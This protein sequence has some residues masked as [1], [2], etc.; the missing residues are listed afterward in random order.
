MPTI[1]ICG[2][3]G[4]GKSSLVRGLQDILSERRIAY[5]VIDK[6]AILDAEVQPIC[7]FIAT[8]LE[9]MRVRISQMPPPARVLFLMWSVAITSTP[10]R[11]D[12]DNMVL[13]DGYWMKHAAAEIAMGGSHASIRGLVEMF[14]APDLTIFLDI[15]PTDALARKRGHLTPYECGCDSSLSERSFLRHQAAVADILRRWSVDF[16]WA[17]ID[18]G[19]SRTHVLDAAAAAVEGALNATG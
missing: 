9:T 8:D 5:E 3:D 13:L 15:E 2:N 1:A 16:G 14:P 10:M 18:A 4:A 19:R 6:W 7:S 12:P 11:K 17:R